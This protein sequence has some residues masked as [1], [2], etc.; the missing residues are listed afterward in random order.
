MSTRLFRPALIVLTLGLVLVP[1]LR[2]PLRLALGRFLAGALRLRARELSSPLGGLTLVLAPHQDD[3]TLGCGGLISLR[4][5]AGHPVHVAFVTDGAASHRGHTM[6]TPERTSAMRALEAR[7]ALRQLG[8]EASA[9][10]FLDAP[11][12]ELAHLS[13]T[14]AAALTSRLAALLDTVCPTEVFLPLH[15]DGSSEH[16]AAFRLFTV[17][18]RSANVRPRIYEFPVWA[19]W[20]PTLLIVPLLRAR[21]IA[22]CQFRGYAFM[23]QRALSAY[24]SQIAPVPPWTEPL[25]SAGF[26]SAFDSPEEFFF[27]FQA[28]PRSL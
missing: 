18:L 20:N 9:L 15:H 14:A 16:E 17:A 13:P 23:K 3:E 1:A 2:L 24:Q 7:E 27:E 21:R 4:R 26:V 22:R 6:L 25:L 8:V 19:R 10:H 5:L 28:L 11:D 12:G